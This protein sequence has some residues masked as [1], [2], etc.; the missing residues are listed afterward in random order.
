MI[1]GHP[2]PALLTLLAFA[3]AA[4]VFVVVFFVAV[5]AAEILLETRVVRHSLVHSLDS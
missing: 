4:A 1:V 3:A 5:A 2:Q